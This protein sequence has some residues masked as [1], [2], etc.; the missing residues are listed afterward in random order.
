MKI[1][2]KYLVIQWINNNPII[3][4]CCYYDTMEDAIKSSKIQEELSKKNL[5]I[6]NDGTTVEYSICTTYKGRDLNH[7]I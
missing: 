1:M 5:Q 7:V 2:K 3:N 6:L 4:G